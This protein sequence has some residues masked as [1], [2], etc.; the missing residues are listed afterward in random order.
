MTFSIFKRSQIVPVDDRSDHCLVQHS[1]HIQNVKFHSDFWH[2]NTGN[3]NGKPFRE[4]LNF[5]RVS[6]QKNKS[7]FSSVQPLWD[8]GKSLIKQF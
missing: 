1:F 7:G 6:H 2:F 8:S 5:L 4:A 3:L